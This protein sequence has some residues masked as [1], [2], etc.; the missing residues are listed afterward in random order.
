LI[1]F[2]DS[3]ALAKRYVREPGSDVVAR[4]F[5]SPSKLAV[6]SLAGIEICAAI[7]RRARAGDLSAELARKHAA[8]VVD[9]LEEVHV[10]EVRGRV[11]DLAME[12]VSRRALRAYDAVQLASAMRL[13]EAAGVAVTFVCAD[14]ALS[15]AAIGEGLRGTHVGR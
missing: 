5:R 14:A 9:D 12:L 1:Y 15:A 7:H 10:L 2:L 3:S 8:R 11:L 13:S 6:S 4:L